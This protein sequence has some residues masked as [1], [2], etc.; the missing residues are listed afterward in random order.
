LR[1]SGLAAWRR[2]GLAALRS[3]GLTALKRRPLAVQSG[4][5]RRDR[6][7]HQEQCSDQCNFLHI[8]RS[9][10]AVDCRPSGATGRDRPRVRVNAFGPHWFLPRRSGH[11]PSSRGLAARGVR[12][13]N[14]KSSAALPARGQLRSAAPHRRRY[15]FWRRLT[16]SAA[17]R[18]GRPLLNCFASR[19]AIASF[20]ESCSKSRRPEAE[21]GR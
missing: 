12:R 15:G 16:A 1:R 19:R 7:R 9:F 21:R 4:D 5:L 10:F 11:C 3:G 2:A 14:A 18:R 8:R 17:V 13:D 6:R 20:S